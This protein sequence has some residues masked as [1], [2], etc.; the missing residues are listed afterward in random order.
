MNKEVL[1][2]VVYKN[3][4]TYKN[5]VR[6]NQNKTNK[7]ININN[8]TDSSNNKK[9]INFN[10]ELENKSNS[11]KNNNDLS[12]SFK[13]FIPKEKINENNYN[14]KII[15]DINYCHILQSFIC[16]RFKRSK[17]INY[18]NDMIIE[19]F[20]MEKIFEKFYKFDIVYNLLSIEKYNKLKNYK[21]KKAKEIN[22][23]ICNKSIRKNNNKEINNTKNKKDGFDIK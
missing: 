13:S 11:E 15:K 4:N 9:E 16:L 18:I 23:N 6:I 7:A 2:S 21:N 22:K 8:I 19:Y 17:I 20:S 1:G 12:K 3:K 5:K 10:E 14:K